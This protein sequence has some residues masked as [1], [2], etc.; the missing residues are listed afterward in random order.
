MERVVAAILAFGLAVQQAQATVQVDRTDV[1]VGG[2]VTLTLSVRASASVPIEITEPAFDGFEV[3][4]RRDRSQVSVEEGVRVTIRDI[5]LRAARPGQLAIPAFRIQQ[6]GSA[7]ESTPIAITVTGSVAVPPVLTPRVRAIVQR[8]VPPAVD[9]T[10]AVIVSVLPSAERVRLGEQ[11]DLVV[12][13]WFPR[14]VRDRLRAPPTVLPP[15]VRGAW[16]YAGSAPTTVVATREARGRTYDLFIFHEIVFALTPGDLEIGPSTVSYNVPVSGSFLSRE[17]RQELQSEPF[18]VA[19]EPPPGDVGP[20]VVA[21]ED[22]AVAVDAPAT[23]LRVGDAAIVKITVS[24][25]GNVALWPEPELRWPPGVQAYQQRATVHVTSVDG[26][27]GGTRAFEYLVVADTAGTHRL[28]APRLVYFDTGNDE[29]RTVEGE[30]V[31]FLTP[32]G[33]RPVS[34]IRAS[35]PLLRRSSWPAAARLPG[36][37]PPWLAMLV[38]LVPPLLVGGLRWRAGLRARRR[39]SPTGPGEPRDGLARLEADVRAVLDRLVP[40]ADVKGVTA[41]T[42]ALVAA[43]VDASLAEHAARVRDRLRSALFG[44]DRTADVD[45]LGEEVQAVLAGL[46]GNGGAA[47]PV[48]AVGLILCCLLLPAAAAAQ[49]V[50]QLWEAGAARAVADSMLARLRS[51]PGAAED[52]YNLGLAWERMGSTAQARAAWLR[53]VRLAPRRG[54]IRR[55]AAQVRA[56]DRTDRD[57]LWP[58]P[59]TPGEAFAGAA[60]LW[61]AGWTALARRRRR[62]AVALLLTA[63]ACAAWGGV[64]GARYGEPLAFVAVS[65]TPLREAPYGPAPSQ[66][67][68]A[69]GVAVRIAERRGAWQL[70]AYGARLG[71]IHE[72]EVVEP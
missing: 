35:L 19:V 2:I 15:D 59:V 25:I 8:A 56:A 72:T 53:A 1:P 65:A 40:G 7:V 69:E 64:V 52:W 47:I 29:L 60:V 54:P 62:L 48:R 5:R 61:M 39:Q 51:D 46:K 43:G 32:E 49:S 16:G 33:P 31:V 44:P 18:L 26:R 21:G 4:D 14:S 63:G 23:E 34:P 10:A 11:L 20:R 41:L 45:E 37:W 13:A 55:A 66:V 27:I 36:R 50:E 22:L 57:L 67:E 28:P 38:V 9:D 58:A 17:V 71:W 24:G 70:V 68:L 42:D 30:A 12:A 6:E 3:V